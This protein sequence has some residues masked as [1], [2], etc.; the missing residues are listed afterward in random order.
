[1]ILSE[2]S[3]SCGASAINEINEQQEEVDIW[4][5]DSDTLCKGCDAALQK[6]ERIR[7]DSSV[8]GWDGEEASPVNVISHNN[9]WRFLIC[10]PLGVPA[11]DPGIDVN[12][13]VTLEWRR[14]DGRL[15]SLTFD[16]QWNVN[17]IVFIESD[18]IYSMRPV[19]LGYSGEL[20]RFL[21]EVIK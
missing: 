9:A 8:E 15:L 1:M 2:I 6:L 4:M 11:P 18:K 12:G 10:I 19:S 7:N 20:K 16:D 14:S 17:Y 5:K 21:E 13:Q 3:Y